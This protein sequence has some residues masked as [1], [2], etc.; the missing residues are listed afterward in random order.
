MKLERIR[1]SEGMTGT[2][3]GAATG[4]DPSHS[5]ADRFEIL[6]AFS[7]AVDR[8]TH[9]ISHRP[10]LLW[11]QLFN[12]LQWEQEPVPGLLEPALELR[13]A[14]L[15]GA[16]PWLRSRTRPRESKALLATFADHDEMVWCCAISPDG[17][18]VVSG[19]LDGVRAWELATA[20]QRVHMEKSG[21]GGAIH[22]CC[23]IS[24]DQRLVASGDGKGTIALWEVESGRKVRTIQAH[25]GEVSACQFNPDGT[26]LVSCSHDGTVKVW[27]VETWRLHFTWGDHE[28]WVQD[29]AF[30]PDGTSVLSVGWEKAL[31]LWDLRTGERKAFMEGEISLDCCA[32]SG[33]GRLGIAGTVGEIQLWN[34][35]KGERS[36]VLR[37]AYGPSKTHRDDIHACLV[38]PDGTWVAAARG[39]NT[40]SLW[41]VNQ[42]SEPRRL[43]GHGGPVLCC[44]VTPD[45]SK[46]V[47]GSTDGTLKVWDSAGEVAAMLHRERFPRLRRAGQSLA[48]AALQTLQNEYGLPVRPD[49]PRHH[50]GAVNDCAFGPDGSWIATCSDDSDVVV[51]SAEDAH[52]IKTLGYQPGT[53]PTISGHEDLVG[54]CAVSGDGSVIVSAGDDGFLVWDRTSGEVRR[55]LGPTAGPG[56][57]P[58]YGRSCA[59]SPDARLV[60]TAPSLK[61]HLIVWDTTN[62][63]EVAVLRG[64]GSDVTDCAWSQDGRVV[65]SAHLD[66]TLTT[67]EVD[68]WHESERFGVM[69]QSPARACAVSDTASVIVSGDDAGTLSIFDGSNGRERLTL[70]SH[71]GGVNDCALSPGGKVAASVGKDGFLRIWDLTQGLERYAA[72]LQSE[73]VCVDLSPTEPRVAIGDTAGNLYLFDLIG[74]GYEA[75]SPR[76][77]GSRQAAGLGVPAS[78]EERRR[79]LE[80]MKL[81]HLTLPP[82]GRPPLWFCLAALAG[83]GLAGVAGLLMVLAG[84]CALAW[85][86]GELDSG[87]ALRLALAGLASFAASLALVLAVIM[88]GRE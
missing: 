5:S 31:N 12:R 74:P 48:E 75:A 7:R 86:S 1:E 61:D 4:A 60:A 66:G 67:W 76:P 8:E 26:Y 72:P 20:K 88:P 23:A 87:L 85:L 54:S 56:G 36:R 84:L 42:D 41:P 34:L 73:A 51:W 47:T 63:E 35:E 46:L 70:R 11:Q 2:P 40:V 13:S 3:G 59:V 16:S 18:F 49:T 57:W 78:K 6:E 14:C 65:V 52:W 32:F 68:G 28:Q 62:G 17:T 69:Q 43:E 71:E 39:D 55:T 81:E 29:C 9:G 53:V 15:S 33:D 30:S 50:A 24:P 22:L 19:G 82:S 27:E 77:P 83:K 58:L 79:W 10:D 44:A 38:S 45:G 37:T 25:D 80:R 64:A 21:P